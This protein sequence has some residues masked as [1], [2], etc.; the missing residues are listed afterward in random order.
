MDVLDTGGVTKMRLAMVDDRVSVER[1]VA[2][3]MK[4]QQADV[5]CQLKVREPTLGI[6]LEE[7]RVAEALAALTDAHDLS[8]APAAPSLGNGPRGTR[9]VGRADMTGLTQPVRHRSGEGR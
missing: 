9:P 6:A 2:L 7:K 8:P 3:G 1:A 5:G 4:C